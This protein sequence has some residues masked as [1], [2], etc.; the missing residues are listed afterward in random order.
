MVFEVLRYFRGIRV[1]GLL[2][3]IEDIREFGAFDALRYFKG[4][5]A[6]GLLRGITAIREFGG[7][8]G[9]SIL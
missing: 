9:S 2:R 1:T 5:R 3:G 7:V 8:R 6:T 4:I